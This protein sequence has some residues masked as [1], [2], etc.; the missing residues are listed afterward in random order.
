M[1]LA[2]FRLIDSNLA[3]GQVNLI[4]LGLVALGYAALARGH[5][6]RAGAW[7]GAA[8][9][10]KVLPALFLV[11]CFLLRRPLAACVGALVAV[12]VAF[13]LPAAAFGVEA[14]VDGVARWFASEAQPYLAGGPALLER[15][16]YVPGHSL[17]AAA[18]RSLAA[19]PAT[20]K[21]AGGPAANVAALE[22]ATV[23]WIVRGLVAAHVTAFVAL[24]VRAGRAT[25]RE[26]ARSAAL[27]LATALV[28][29]P[30]VHKA[31][32]VWLV[33]V[34]TVLLVEARRGSGPVVW[35]LRVLLG[36]SIGLVALSVP[37]LFGSLARDFAT[38]NALFFGLESAWIA[39]VLVASVRPACTSRE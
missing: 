22:L 4:T 19:I 18:Y 37:A 32:L 26:L 39:T 10:L 30:L 25:G 34:W 6:L 35:A 38:H 27:A 11:H 2:A 16:D 31:H 20:S 13:G 7:I 29:G 5:A 1:L 15:R 14:A 24:T 9:A 21:G 36:L 12:A 28:V 23:A 33:P 17:T 3:Y 8:T